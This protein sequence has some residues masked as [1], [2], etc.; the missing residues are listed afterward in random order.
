MRVLLKV[1]V[2]VSFMIMTEQLFQFNVIPE[3]RITR[4]SPMAAFLV[5]GPLYDV[6]M[7][8]DNRL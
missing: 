3:V 1:M 8:E 7:D 2:L 5:S 6:R 4:R